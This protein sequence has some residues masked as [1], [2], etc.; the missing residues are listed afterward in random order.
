M[1]PLHAKTHAIMA[2]TSVVQFVLYPYYVEGK[3]GRAEVFCTCN[4]G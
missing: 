1:K 4:K 2:A 3:N